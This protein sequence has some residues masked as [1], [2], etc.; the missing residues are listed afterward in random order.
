MSSCFNYS[1]NLDDNGH[2]VSD[3]ICI[4]LEHMR[5]SLVETEATLPLARCL[6]Q[7]LALWQFAFCAFDCDVHL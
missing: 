7:Q 6:L 3:I 4:E 2:D 5:R 1:A